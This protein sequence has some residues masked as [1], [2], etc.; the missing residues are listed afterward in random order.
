MRIYTYFFLFSCAFDVR[1]ILTLGPL[2]GASVTVTA[3]EVVMEW[4]R[5]KILF[6]YLVWIRRFPRRRYANTSELLALLRY[7]YFFLFSIYTNPRV[8]MYISVDKI[9]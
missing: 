5:R 9:I 6:L 3:E 7:A 2:Q 8:R 1:R 4:L